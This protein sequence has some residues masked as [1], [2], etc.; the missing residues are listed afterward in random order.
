MNRKYNC[1]EFLNKI[2]KIKS[3]IPN[4]AL[5]TDVIVGF[6]LESDEEFFETYQFIK[7]CEFNMLHV[8]PFS[9]REGTAA[10]EMKGQIDP[11]IKNLRAHTLLEL[12]KNLWEEYSNRFINATEEV[13]FEEFDKETST[14]IGHT[15]NY[16]HVSIKN[17]SNLVGKIEK[18][19]IK[20][21]DII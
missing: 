11:Q 8:F 18:I 7:K 12:S 1:E 9:A 10:Y 14:N 20:K 19:T 5:T 17:P 13:L 16:L 6:P 4:I 21:C 15:S 3:L 2:K